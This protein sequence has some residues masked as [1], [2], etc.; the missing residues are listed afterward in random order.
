MKNLSKILSKYRKICLMYKYLKYN[1]LMNNRIIIKK[2]R[3]IN[4]NSNVAIL[5]YLK[6][7]QNKINYHALYLKVNLLIQFIFN[8][9][10]MIIFVLNT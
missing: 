10:L 1:K 6:Q 4:Q 8:I 7:L 9:F 2:T 5:T 3:K